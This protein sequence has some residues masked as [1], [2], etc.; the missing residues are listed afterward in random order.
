M[1]TWFGDLNGHVGSS[2]DGYVRLCMVDVAVV[3]ET[4]T[5]V[6]GK[7]NRENGQF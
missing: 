3:R 2:G 7:K 1:Y 4:L 5:N 6:D